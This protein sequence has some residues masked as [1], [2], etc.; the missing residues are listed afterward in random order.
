[1]VLDEPTAHLDSE[2]E[3]VIQHAIADYAKNNLVL[4]IAHRLNT[5][6][7]AEQLIVMHNGKIAQQGCF[8]S[9]AAEDGEFATLLQTAQQGAVHA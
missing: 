2:T 5:V 8:N 9:L 6:K 1:M 7:N 3:Q 4:V